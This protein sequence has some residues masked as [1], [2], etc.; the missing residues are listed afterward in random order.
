[1]TPSEGRGAEGRPLPR[2]RGEPALGR[3]RRGR[4]A[5]AGARGRGDRR[6]PA[7]GAHA[8]APAARTPRSSPC[9]AR[10]ARTGPCRSC[11]RSWRSPTPARG[12]SPASAPWTRWWPRRTSP[13]RASTPRRAYA[14]RQEA[15][16]ELGAGDAI[17]EIRDR[18]GLPL[19][20]KP[21]KQ[22]SAL[23]ITVAHEPADVP[24]A[25]MSALAYDDRV[26]LERFVPGREL[27][28][29][30]HRHR[31]ARGRCRWSRRSRAAATSTTSRP[32]TPPA[33]PTSSRPPGCSDAVAQE[34]ARVA[35]ACYRALGLP[36][37]EPGGHDP[38]RRRAPLGARDQPD[39]RDDGHAACCRR[40]PRRPGWASTRWWRGSWPRPRSVPE[41]LAA[42]LALTA[43]VAGVTG[44][45]SPCGFSMI[46]TLGQGGRGGRATWLA[47]ATF[48]VGRG[49]RRRRHL[50]RPVAAGRRRSR[51]AGA[52]RRAGRGGARGRPWR[53]PAS[54]PGC[55]SCPRSAARCR[56]P[57]AG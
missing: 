33:S 2:A 15:F 12:C 10:A 57:G 17:S 44:A 3:Q 38:R 27:A 46:D 42:V 40:P 8:C 37:R 49:G 14:F 4:P 48:T 45:W 52:D 39:P 43:L 53:P 30:V 31:R 26:L 7:P 13:R 20:V 23:G 11:S 16:R 29:S 24:A 5:P 22:G 9:T 54:G 19:V 32:A 55:A 56:S 34:V 51:R 25:L 35:I 36:G 6:Q 18:L 21:A 47:C 41:A 1:M 28:V 50:R